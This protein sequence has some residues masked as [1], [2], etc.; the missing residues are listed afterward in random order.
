MFMALSSLE[1]WKNIIGV[2][3]SA[4]LVFP[5]QVFPVQFFLTGHRTCWIKV[6]LAAQ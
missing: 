3:M 1:F 4:F 2:L 6:V 5:T